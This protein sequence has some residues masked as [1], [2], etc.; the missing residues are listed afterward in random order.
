[1][2]SGNF[3]PVG[4]G[5]FKP[6]SK[7]AASATEDINYTVGDTVRHIKFGKGVVTEMI[8]GGSDYEITVNFDSVGEKKMFASLAK[9]K[10]L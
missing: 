6:V 4:S 8:K 9:L 5:S 7:P 1:M 3:K 10:K 2:S